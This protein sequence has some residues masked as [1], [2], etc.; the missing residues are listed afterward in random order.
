LYHQR[1]GANVEIAVVSTVLVNLEQ[2]EL[3][4]GFSELTVA[5]MKLDEHVNYP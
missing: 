3:G 5:A 4:A 1:T 2:I